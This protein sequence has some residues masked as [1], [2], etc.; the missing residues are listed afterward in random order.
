MWVL[1]IYELPHTDI[2]ILNFRTK[3]G[4]LNIM[5][6]TMKT[7]FRKFNLKYFL[8]LLLAVLCGI[9][10]Y[11]NS[12]FTAHEE[13]VIEGIMAFRTSLSVMEF[14]NAR[15]KV[16]EYRKRVLSAEECKTL[17]EQA[18][19]VI[20]TF[21]V[22]ETY[23]Y[24][25]EADPNDSRLKDL[26]LPQMRKLE[27]FIKVHAESEINEWLY[28]VAGDVISC[29]L[30]FLPKAEAMKKG[31]VIK[32]YYLKALS[33]K[34]DCWYTLINTAQWFFQAPAIGGGSKDKARTYFEKAY[35][36]AKTPSGKYYTSIMLSQSR[37]ADD[38]KDEADSLLSKARNIIPES[39]FVKKIAS[40]NLIGHDYFYYVT[41]RDN[42]DKKLQK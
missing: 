28:T 37:Y 15:A 18:Q 30:R 22:M 24:I 13:E 10:G 8:C 5:F 38:K 27:D 16:D 11:A 36:A 29:C 1:V 17:S 9:S 6:D 7:G 4:I 2:S 12:P 41:H 32:D 14:A 21:L 20:D 25:Y 26:I 23:N 19:L 31:L 33:I 3:L 34:S 35:A 42:I 39:K 40:I